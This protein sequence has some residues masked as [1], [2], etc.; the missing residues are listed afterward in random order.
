MSD[1]VFCSQLSQQEGEQLFGTA[2]SNIKVWFALEYNRPWRA[3]ATVDNDLPTAVQGWLNDQLEKVGNGRLQF[4]R[5]QKDNTPLSFFVG[6]P[7]NGRL[8]RFELNNYEELFQLDIAAVVAGAAQYE[9]FLWTEP[10]YLVC[11]NGKRDRCCA[12]WGMAFYR[13]LQPLAG[14]AVWQTTH[15][16]GHRFAPTLLT[17]PDGILHGRLALENV[18]D[19]LTAH[20]QGKLLLDNYRGHSHYEPVVQVADYFLRQTTGETSLSAYR[21]HQHQ[22][23]NGSQWRVQ[24]AQDDGTVHEVVVAVE[25]AVPDNLL[26][27]CDKLQVKPISQYTYLA[28]SVNGKR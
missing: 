19:F 15:T 24:F 27:S 18:A 1:D 16:G 12:L 4:I 3:K 20:Q 9:A 7:E 11:T 6:L 5:Q 8:Y 22:N 13:A 28:H 23:G 26:A 14:T 2:V 10:L 17:L 25:T 21:Y